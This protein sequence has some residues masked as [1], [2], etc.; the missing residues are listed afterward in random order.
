MRPLRL[1]ILAAFLAGCSITPGIKVLATPNPLSGDGETTATVTATVTGNTLDGVIAHFTTD[2]GSF[3]DSEPGTPGRASIAVDSSGKAVATLIAPRQGWGSVNLGV[4]ASIDGKEPSAATSLTLKPSGGLANNISFTCQH[5]NIGAFVTGRLTTIHLLC[6]ATAYDAQSRIVPKASV[7]TLTEAGTL[8]WLKDDQGVQQFVYSV[9]PDAPPPKDVDPLDSNGN[10]QAVCPAGCVTNAFGSSCTGEPCWTDSTGITH[11]PRDG[12]ATII[13][14]VPGAP[15][16]ETKGEPF[17]DMN[18]NGVRDPGEPFIDYNGNGKWDANDG[19]IKPGLVWKA[20]RIVWSGE[21]SIPPSGLGTHHSYMT[22][23][24]SAVTVFFVDKNLNALAADGPS[25]SDSVDWTADC[26]KGSTIA[27]PSTVMDQ[28]NPGILFTAETGAISAP[29][30]RMT[31]TRNI[32]YSN[33]VNLAAGVTSDTCGITAG[34]HRAYD[35]GAP[36]YAPEGANPDAA[37]ITSFAFP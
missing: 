8:D 3:K 18:D 31:Y 36:G 34:P 29:M 22:K 33:S 20:Y 37:L 35:P 15:G 23:T 12:V 28:V 1:G 4:S 13:A 11:N 10:P 6:T 24:G 32:N 5:Q 26:A 30:N 2:L 16:A 14:A 21:A 25:A 19:Q 9:R 27:V 7:Q 17:V